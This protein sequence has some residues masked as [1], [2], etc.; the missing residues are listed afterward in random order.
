ME[1]LKENLGLVFGFILAIVTGAFFY[2]RSRRQSAEA[3]ADNQETIDKINDGDKKIIK[4]EA[5]NQ[6]EEEKRADIKEEI[7]KQQEDDS[8]TVADFLNKRK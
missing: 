5:I 7:K 6:A 1:K 4:N 3:I 8:E 2:E